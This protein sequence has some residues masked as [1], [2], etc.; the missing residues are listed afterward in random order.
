MIGRI[1]L[2]MNVLIGSRI[3]SKS[4]RKRY[5]YE[6][7]KQTGFL[8]FLFHVTCP[9]NSAYSY[10]WVLKYVHYVEAKKRLGGFFTIPT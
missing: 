1:V 5:L 2:K 8:S 9:A 7:R 3:V 6:T 4:R 10:V